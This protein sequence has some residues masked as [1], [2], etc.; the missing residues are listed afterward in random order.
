VELP[1]YLTMLAE[2]ER[3]LADADECLAAGHP[4]D[5][6]I[7]FACATFA[8][9]AHERAADV[10]AARARLPRTTAAPDDLAGAPSRESRSG[11]L[12]LLRDL[13]DVHQ[14]AVFVATAWELV[15][16]AAHGIRDRELIDLAARCAKAA[17]EQAAWMRRKMA[18][19][20]A[21]SLLA[22]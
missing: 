15:G 20:A 1:H 13:A 5:A 21:Q 17:G 3:T 22:S 2:A 4:A 18:A 11:A 10:D 8:R 6:E 7:V 19:E 14:Q 12:G 16:Q 9:A